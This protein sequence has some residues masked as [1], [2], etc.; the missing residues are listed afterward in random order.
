MIR[1][2]KL[3]GKV[4]YAEDKGDYMSVTVIQT[5]KGAFNDNAASDNKSFDEKFESWKVYVRGKAD[6]QPKKYYDF[7]NVYVGMSAKNGKV[8][9][10][11]LPENVHEHIF[12]N[13]NNGYNKSY[14]NSRR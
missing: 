12:D 11:C 7:D 6:I 4:Q 3:I 9:V 1:A 13:N 5:R 2:G 10:S 8:F 14:N